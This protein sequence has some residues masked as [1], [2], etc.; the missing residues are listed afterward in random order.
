M[1]GQDEDILIVS[2]RVDGKTHVLFDGLVKDFRFSP[3]AI[4]GVFG[5]SVKIFFYFIRNRWGRHSVPSLL[6]VKWPHRWSFDTNQNAICELFGVHTEELIRVF[7][8]LLAGPKPLQALK[9]V[10]VLVKTLTPQSLANKSFTFAPHFLP[11]ERRRGHSRH[12]VFGRTSHLRP[13]PEVHTSTYARGGESVGSPWAFLPSTTYTSFHRQYTSVNTPNF[14]R[15]KKSE[16]PVNPYSFVLQTTNL[17]QGLHF[18][19]LRSNPTAAF[20]NNAL[21]SDSIIDGIPA[22]PDFPG[23]LYNAVVRKLAEHAAADVNNVAQDFVQY[24][25]TT[26]MIANSATRIAASVRALKALDFKR[27]SSVLFHNTGRRDTRQGNPTVSKSLANNWLELQYGWKPLLLDIDGSMRALAQFVQ[28]Q[29]TV[30]TVRASKVS[31]VWSTWPVRYLSQPSEVGV[32]VPSPFPPIGKG[33][34]YV[35][36]QVRGALRYRPDSRHTS[37]LSQTGFTSPVN[38]AWELLPWSFVVDWFLP[39]GPYLESFSSFEGMDFVDGSITYYSHIVDHSRVAYNGALAYTP[40]YDSRV[41]ALYDYELFA[42]ERVKLTGF[43]GSLQP[44]F[45]NPVTTTHAL[46]ALALLRAS[47]K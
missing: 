12:L 38:L 46:N 5:G 30:R 20:F 25:Q 28:A 45:K 19:S 10:S 16:L 3:R 47:F 22:L 33:D 37:F 36:T 44:Q 2:A 27:A 41:R 7:P 1:A 18:R 11:V 43:P 29:P 6:L 4:R 26:R 13:N 21:G 9:S 40:S 35:R 32:P 15:K 34:R 8:I 24:R 39:I 14:K 23:E 42:V 17:G 31:E